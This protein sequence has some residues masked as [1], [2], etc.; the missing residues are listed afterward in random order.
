MNIQ[1]RSLQDVPGINAKEIMEQGCAPFMTPQCT[2]GGRR[3]LRSLDSDTLE[4][5][6]KYSKAIPECLHGSGY[7]SRKGI[8]DWIAKIT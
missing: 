8:M 6:R 1:I 4:A 3:P 2:P 7:D 5:R